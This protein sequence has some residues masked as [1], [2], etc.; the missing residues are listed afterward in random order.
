MIEKAPADPGGFWARIP[1]DLRLWR[2]H[3]KKGLALAEAAGGWQ[4]AA[5]R[6][7]TRY[8]NVKRPNT[9]GRGDTRRV[10]HIERV[11]GETGAR[12]GP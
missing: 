11:A 5:H 7:L 3:L 8:L 2:P 1:R 9:P 6:V 10:Q 4:D 12:A